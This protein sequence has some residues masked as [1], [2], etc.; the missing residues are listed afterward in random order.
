MSTKI[1]SPVYYPWIVPLIPGIQGENYMHPLMIELVW[2][3]KSWRVR[4]L[5][6]IVYR[7]AWSHQ[8]GPCLLAELRPKCAAGCQNCSY[9][10]DSCN[11]AIL[12][13][14][15]H[16]LHKIFVSY[17][18]HVYIYRL[19]KPTLLPSLKALIL[20]GSI[21]R[22]RRGFVNWIQHQSYLTSSKQTN[23]Y[24]I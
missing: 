10:W 3:S 8:F 6:N 14:C 18:I 4:P 15:L 22:G 23:I 5:S 17:H 21:I 11:Y 9:W 16:T 1:L 12:Q 24:N 2:Q 20:N 13:Y 19:N 7:S